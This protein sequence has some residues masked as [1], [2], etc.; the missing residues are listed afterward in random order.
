MKDLD[1]REIDII[2]V[3]INIYIH[4]LYKRDI[5][6]IFIVYMYIIYA[7]MYIYLHV[8]T[9]YQYIIRGYYT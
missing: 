1:L 7:Y 6:C 8:Y 5:L 2:Y 3:Y 4:S 9:V